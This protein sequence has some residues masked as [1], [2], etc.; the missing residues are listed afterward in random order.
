MGLYFL[1]THLMAADSIYS[2]RT[3]VLL[4]I[5]AYY[6]NVFF[7]DIATQ[8]RDVFFKGGFLTLAKGF[9]RGLGMVFTGKL[10]IWALVVLVLCVLFGLL[11][12]RQEV[13]TGTGRTWMAVLSGI[14]LALGPVSLFFVL[15]TT[16]WFSMRGAVTSLPG[17]A[18]TIDAMLLWLADRLAIRK[19]A[20]QAVLAATVALACCVAGASEVSDYRD[21]YENDQYAAHLVLD[22]M[23]ADK[24]DP[25]TNQVGILNLEPSY[26]DSQ[27]F[28]YHEHIHGCTESS[29]AFNGLLSAVSGDDHPSVTPLPSN[30]MYKAWNRAA[31]HPSGFTMLYWFNGTELIPAELEELAENNYL[32]RDRFG[33]ELGHI[34]EEDGIGYIRPAEG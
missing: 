2:S 17:I 26:L 19:S 30:P 27:N 29:W 16:P 32:V 3:A 4:P 7:P 34:W 15:D 5:T 31:N 6:W 23:A 20:F 24:I 33:R 8:I 10:A 14:L 21:T 18:L 1:Y 22:T 25:H 11:A 9:V 12:H 13:K 28:F